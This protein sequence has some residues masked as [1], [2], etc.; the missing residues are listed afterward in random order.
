MNGKTKTNKTN[1]A[2]ALKQIVKIELPKLV[3]DDAAR[4]AIAKQK[5]IMLCATYKIARRLR[6]VCI[7]ARRILDHELLAESCELQVEIEHFTSTGDDGSPIDR[8]YAKR[9]ATDSRYYCIN[10]DLAFCLL[11]IARSLWAADLGDALKG[12]L[13]ALLDMLLKGHNR[14]TEREPLSLDALKD[15]NRRLAGRPLAEVV[16]IDDLIDEDERPTAHAGNIIED[17]QREIVERPTKTQTTAKQR[18]DDRKRAKLQGKSAK[19]ASARNGNNEWQTPDYILDAAR[20]M[21][22]DCGALV[23]KRNQIDLDAASSAAANQRIKAN[24]FYSEQRSALRASSSWVARS[25]WLNPP[26]GAGLISPFVFR[27]I[28]EYKLVRFDHGLMLTNVDSST[29]WY[30]AAAYEFPIVLFKERIAFID[31]TTGKPTKGNRYQ[32]A[33]FYAGEHVETFRQHFERF[34]LFYYAARYQSALR[35]GQ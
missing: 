16:N 19:K 14:A 33:I 6:A 26:Y 3:P 32:Q 31:P 9:Y 35:G 20:A 28:D 25:L 10:V 7:E 18:A 30:H 11:D 22:Q 21:F 4:D 23:G 5:T 12:E 15:A 13:C 17:L 24:R 29:R 2:E 8:E 27:F 1:K 34:G